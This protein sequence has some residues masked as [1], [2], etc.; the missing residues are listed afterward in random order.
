MGFNPILVKLIDLLFKV[1]LFLL[2][3]LSERISSRAHPVVAWSQRMIRAGKKLSSSLGEG[4]ATVCNAG[5][6]MPMI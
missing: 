4:Q 3:N 6:P 1:V 5:A 2:A